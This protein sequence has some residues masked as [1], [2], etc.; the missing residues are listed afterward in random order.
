[1]LYVGDD[2]EGLVWF[3]RSGGEKV[4]LTGSRKKPS[5]L[6]GVLKEERLEKGVHVRI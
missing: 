3:T 4:W 2:N 1:M 6:V 5:C